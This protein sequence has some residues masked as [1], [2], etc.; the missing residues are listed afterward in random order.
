MFAGILVS[1]P[2]TFAVHFHH[3]P[4][5]SLNK[6]FTRSLALHSL[7]QRNGS[8]RIMHAGAG[9]NRADRKVAALRARCQKS[10]TPL[11]KWCCLRRC[12][13]TRKSGCAQPTIAL[14]GGHLH[15]GW[16]AYPIFTRRTEQKLIAPVPGHCSPPESAAAKLR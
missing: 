8:L 2:A 15:C 11:L 7:R 10:V 4:L 9:Q 12:Q 1:E 14:P 3:A 5:R 13:G 16:Q 6:L